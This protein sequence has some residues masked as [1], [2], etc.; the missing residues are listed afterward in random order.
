MKKYILITLILLLSLSVFAQRKHEKIH[1]LKIAFITEQL[2]LTE[3]E[4]QEFW[5]VYNAHNKSFRHKFHQM[6]DIRR[7]IKSNL[8][9]LTDEKA[10]ELMDKLDDIEA[11]LYQERVEVSKKLRAILPPSKLI[12]LKIAEEDFKKKNAG[13]L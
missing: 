7:D 5:A 4:A 2:D 12:K 10:L 3:K 6:R 13:S 11:K 9:T 1:S 8:N